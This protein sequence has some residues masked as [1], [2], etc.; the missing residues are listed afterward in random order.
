MDFS[1]VLIPAALDAAA[2]ILANVKAPMTI[3][4]LI[5]ALAAKALWASL[6]GKTPDRTLYSAISRE[7]AKKDRALRFKK[8]EK[9]KF[10]LR[11]EG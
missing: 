9:G 7:I 11:G 10:G 3:K 8:A 4:G 1:S 6:E 2:E 5:E